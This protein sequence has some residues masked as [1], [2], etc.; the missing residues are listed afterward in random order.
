MR[1]IK[2][3]IKTALLKLVFAVTLSVLYIIYFYTLLY[4][5]IPYLFYNYLKE[6]LQHTYLQNIVEN[7]AP[8]SFIEI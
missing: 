2:L 8:L 7:L 3:F 1:K 4:T 6:P 5:S